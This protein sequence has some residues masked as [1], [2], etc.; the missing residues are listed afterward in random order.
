MIVNDNR[1]THLNNE[2]KTK[3]D[4]LSTNC[5]RIQTKVT[6]TFMPQLNNCRGIDL[7]SL[8][9]DGFCF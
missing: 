4:E 6:K 5:G 9:D 1:I 3:N 2:V 8:F 7:S